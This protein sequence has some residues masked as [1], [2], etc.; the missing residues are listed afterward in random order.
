MRKIREHSKQ[1]KSINPVPISE[2]NIHTR[3][4][5][6][7]ENKK[8]ESIQTEDV[9]TLSTLAQQLS[10]VPLPI[11]L[12]RAYLSTTITGHVLHQCV[13][14][15]RSPNRPKLNKRVPVKIRTRTTTQ[16]TRKFSPITVPGTPPKAKTSPTQS[17]EVENT[18]SEVEDINLFFSISNRFRREMGESNAASAPRHAEI[19]EEYQRLRRQRPKKIAQTKQEKGHTLSPFKPVQRKVKFRT[20]A[21]REPIIE[22]IDTHTNN[23]QDVQ[24]DSEHYLYSNP[25]KPPTPQ[26]LDLI[27]DTGASILM[28]PAAYTYA[29]KNLRPCLHT[30]TEGCFAGQEE[31]NLQIGEFHGIITLDTGET[32]RAIIPECVQT[33]MGV[34]KTNLLADTAYLMAGHKYLSHLSAC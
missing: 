21:R 7:T 11:D 10:L 9:L 15:I 6:Q 23:V 18:D 34:S 5:N 32:R 19:D 3:D 12:A 26:V 17:K 33:P 14:A 27:Y 4:N 29:W 25:D 24:M 22:P 2:Y 31:S 30:L 28:M 20:T 16:R 8:P 13:N 1:T